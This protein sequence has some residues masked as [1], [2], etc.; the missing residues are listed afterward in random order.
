M[1]GTLN[2]TA[3]LAHPILSVDIEDLKDA[4]V[5]LS[6]ECPDAANQLGNGECVDRM[7]QASISNLLSALKVTS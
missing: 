6:A 7:R 4:A 5:R 1:V 2:W 3:R